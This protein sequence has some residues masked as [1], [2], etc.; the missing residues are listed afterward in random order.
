MQLG[1]GGGNSH[2]TDFLRSAGRAA[3]MRIGSIGCRTSGD[4]HGEKVGFFLMVGGYQQE[5][6]TVYQ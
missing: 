3:A 2:F 6:S 5:I 1:V 4:I